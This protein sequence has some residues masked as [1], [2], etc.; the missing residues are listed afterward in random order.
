METVIKNG[1]AKGY[2]YYNKKICKIAEKSKLCNNPKMYNVL[3]AIAYKNSAP[4]WIMLGIMWKESR[5]GT[6]YH[7]SNTDDCLANTNNRHWS[8]ANHN[9]IKAKRTTR[10]WHGCWL[11]KYDSIEEWFASLSYTVGVGY[12]WCMNNSRPAY[13][14]SKLYVGSPDVYEYSRYSF[15]ESW[16]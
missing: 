14:M 10:V 6:A 7:K 1:E 8:K 13:C 5:F 11:Q 15:V 9:G 4:L 12:K 16:R 2:D 3:E